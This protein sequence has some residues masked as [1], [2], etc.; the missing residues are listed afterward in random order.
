MTHARDVV[1]LHG[2][3]GP[4]DEASWLGPLN[5]RLAQM[6]HSRFDP[7]HDRITTPSYLKELLLGIPGSEPE[8]TWTKGS[9]RDHQQ[10]RL[11]YLQRQDEL[12]RAGRTW[13][14]FGAGRVVSWL[15]DDLADD[16]WVTRIGI[17]FVHSVRLYQRDRNC[18]WAAQRAVLDQ[19][20]RSGAIILIAHSLG[21]VIALDLLTKLHPN[22]TVDLLLTIGSPL[23]I[24]RLG[25]PGF[26][27]FPYDR[28]GG[29]VN[30]YDPGDIVTVGCGVGRRFPAACDITVETGQSHAAA[31][32][33]SNPAAAAVVGHHAF[34]GQ[35]VIRRASI[36]RRLHPAWQP[37]L[38]SFAYSNQLSSCAKSR[39]W[40]FKA[41]VDTARA[42]LARRTVAD[43]DTK[44]QQ[45]LQ[46][47]ALRLEDSP[48]G[49]GRFPNEDDLLHHAS[50]LVRDS[51]TDEA[52]LSLA[53]GLEM[54]PPLHPFDVKISRQQRHIALLNTL[55]RVRAS[56]GEVSVKE[57]AEAV[58][59]G[60]RAGEN[61]VK[62]SGFPWGT[63]LISGGL[64]LLSITGVGLAVAAPAG[65]AGAAVISGTL[66]AFGPGGLVGGLITIATLTGV[67]AAATGI[68]VA[69][70]TAE[71]PEVAERARRH[72]VEELSTMPIA[73]LR[74]AVAGVLAVVDAQGRL[75]FEST[76]N[77]VEEMLTSALDKI[78]A[79]HALHEAVAP[80]RAGTREWRNKVQLLE[81]ALG[82]LQATHLKDDLLH[83]TR[84]SLADLPGSMSHGEADRCQLS[85]PST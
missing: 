9:E 48:V 79:E 11:R 67:G 24:K 20:P 23:A 44:R 76:G 2:A 75:G 39:E 59:D 33:L 16:G 18:R 13:E 27:E 15:P 6:G 34:G 36:Q 64:L 77:L 8:R 32:Y 47:N 58:R 60:V 46:D 21:S 73:A 70:G 62:E 65:V 42:L 45:L 68:G 41:R 71:D 30:L 19:I 17:S 50:D 53:V 56:Y 4:E 25:D 80:D 72:A 83:R 52:L 31:A 85:G 12:S 81:R 7:G 28:V 74:N 57:F 54:S 49:E 22:L 5:L 51:W 63:V 61:A 82:W 1:F 55:S 14:R 29:W 69:V 10:S 38:L 40:L 43:V 37:L 35:A 26:A 84:E 3:S 66:A 78:R